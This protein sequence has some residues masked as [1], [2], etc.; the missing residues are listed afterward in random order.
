MIDTELLRLE[1]IHS[2][3]IPQLDSEEVQ[4][5][6]AVSTRSMKR[7]S[8]E[9]ESPS[10]NDKETKVKGEKRKADDSDVSEL[11]DDGMDQ[12][13]MERANRLKLQEQPL[14]KV[15]LVYPLNNYFHPLKRKR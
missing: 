7:E 1:L 12:Y 4:H 9:Q 11:L 5:G 2:P 14:F 6:G 15:H 8:E 10:Q 3:S 13:L